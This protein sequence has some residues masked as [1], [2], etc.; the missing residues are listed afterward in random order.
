MCDEE[1]HE[2]KWKNDAH[3]SPYYNAASHSRIRPPVAYAV[4]TERATMKARKYATPSRQFTARR[5]Q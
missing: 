3:R 4:M 1:T 5:R 2:G